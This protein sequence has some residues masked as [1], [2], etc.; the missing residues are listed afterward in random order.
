MV[1]LWWPGQRK[2]ACVTVLLEK[3]TSPSLAKKALPENCIAYGGSRER[4]RGTKGEIVN[5]PL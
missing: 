4:V 5:W 1:K 2:L 3:T